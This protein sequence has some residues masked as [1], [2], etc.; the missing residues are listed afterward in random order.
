MALSLINTTTSSGLDAA[1]TVSAP[2]GTSGDVLFVIISHN[3]GTATVADNNGSTPTTEDLDY[4]FGTM[5]GGLAIYHR[6]IG[7]S[8][9]AS[10]VYTLSASNRWAMT[11]F[12][13]RGVD[14]AIYDVA[15]AA[16][17]NVGVPAASVIS[18]SITTLSNNAWSIACG[19]IDDVTGA[20]NSIGGSWVEIA[21]VNAQQ[22]LLVSYLAKATAGATGDVTLTPTFSTNIGA[23][24]QFSIKEAAAASSG[25]AWIRA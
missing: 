16:S 22:P 9:P 17:S 18:G 21:K 13:L 19:S 24:L 2:A 14:A 3:T 11:A 25:L 23:L 12:L 4:D 10:Y 5:T 20:W 15:P 8:E 6:T 1:P 7:G